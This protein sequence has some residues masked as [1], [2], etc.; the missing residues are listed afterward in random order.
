MME[1]NQVIKLG[2]LQ[3]PASL[4]MLSIGLLISVV[5]V[6]ILSKREGRGTQVRGIHARGAQAK[7]ADFV[8]THLL[9][10]LVIYKF[11]WII[12]DLKD[13]INNPSIIFWMSSSSFTMAFVVTLIVFLYK[14]R[15][16]N[17]SLFEILDNIF[18]SFTV[19]LLTYSLFIIDYGK[20]TNFI[21]GISIKGSSDYTYHPINW[22]KSALA[23]ALILLRYKW[24]INLDLV[25]LLEL[26]I[27]LGAGLL[28]IS[29]LDVHPNLVYGFSLEQ[30][31]YITIT[32]IGSIGLIRYSNKR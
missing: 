3:I 21:L 16:S 11:G 23:I 17:Y 26:Y 18:I 7:W 28:L 32:L 25:R 12:F 30:W 8:L 9:V 19:I 14:I 13:V 10:F 5:I 1:V 4:L 24:R 2:P 20:A 6:E 29:I 15:R 22:Y 27:V 31:A